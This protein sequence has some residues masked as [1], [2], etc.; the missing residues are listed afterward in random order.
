M[1]GCVF[2][3]Q[4]RDCVIAGASRP[5]NLATY[6]S[7]LL[8]SQACV[9]F[10]PFILRRIWRIM[11]TGAWKIYCRLGNHIFSDRAGNLPTAVA[12]SLRKSISNM[13]FLITTT[14]ECAIVLLKNDDSAHSLYHVSIF[15][16]ADLVL[17]WLMRAHSKR[18]SQRPLWLCRRSLTLICLCSAWSQ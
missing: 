16:H 12:S 4:T 9:T 2:S 11:R 14:A 5:H 15:S 7:L 10:A 8:Y 3:S 13:L 17:A 6:E 18:L 1:F